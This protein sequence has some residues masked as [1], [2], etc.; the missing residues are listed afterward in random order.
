MPPTRPPY[1]SEFKAEAVMLYQQRGKKLQEIA[2]DLG[3]S[4]NSLREWARR[5]KG[6]DVS[7]G[8]SRTSLSQDEREDLERGCS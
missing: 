7:N 1:P 6:N 8:K 3:I 5:A 4:A 2:S